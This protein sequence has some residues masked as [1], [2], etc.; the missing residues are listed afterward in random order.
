[1]SPRSLL[2]FFTDPQYQENVYW[3]KWIIKKCSIIRP[4]YWTKFRLAGGITTCYLLHNE[5]IFLATI[6]LGIFAFTDWIDGK[7]ARYINQVSD[8]GAFWDAIA[9]KF[10]I[11][12]TLFYQICMMIAP[13]SEWSVTFWVLFLAMILAEASR[14]FMLFS[15]KPKEKLVHAISWG[16]YKFLLQVLLAFSLCLMIMIWKEPDKILLTMTIFMSLPIITL[17]SAMSMLFRVYPE[18]EKEIF[19]TKKRE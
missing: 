10:F 5:E 19:R 11:L 12:P 2:S 17:L 13:R 15:K 4:N 9:D 8:K 6:S 1:M 7:V 14:L 18:L 16:K 3:V